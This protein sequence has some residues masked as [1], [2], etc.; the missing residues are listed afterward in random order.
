M[1][2]QEAVRRYHIHLEALQ[3]CEENGLL[4]GICTTDKNRDYREEDL[5]QVSQ[6]AFLLKAGMDTDMLKQYSRLVQSRTNTAFEQIKILRKCRYRLLE[7]IHK[8][9]Q[10]LDQLDYLIYEIRQQHR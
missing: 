9:Q 5:L 6:F 1:T 7:E 10:V 3:F 2:I 4:S 8:K